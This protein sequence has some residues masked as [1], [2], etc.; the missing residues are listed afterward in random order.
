MK[1]AIP[2]VQVMLGIQEKSLLGQGKEVRRPNTFNVGFILRV[3]DPTYNFMGLSS[4]VS[5]NEE[6]YVL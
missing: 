6:V 4:L 2:R 1:K 5:I 3:V